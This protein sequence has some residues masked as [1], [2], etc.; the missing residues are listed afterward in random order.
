MV[1]TKKHLWYASYGSNI[2]ESRFHCY[3]KGGQPE[4]SSKKYIGCSNN[5]LPKSKKEITIN[6]ELYFAKKSKSWDKGGVCFIKNNI[7]KNAKTLGRMYLITSDQYVEIV[8]QETN[9]EGALVIDFDRAKELGSYIFKRK[10]WYGNLIYLGEEDCY[11]IFTFTNEKN[12]EDEINPPSHNYL[13]SIIT[14][15][16]ETYK[17]NSIEIKKYFEDKIGIQGFEIEKQL[18][19]IIK[20]KKNCGQQH[21]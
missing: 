7:D 21:L 20:T 6:R 9:H 11:P 1:C 19:E 17:L 8:I 16:K 5:E 18:N 15:L 2:L 14:G 13:L 12:L 10:S 4:G 3:I